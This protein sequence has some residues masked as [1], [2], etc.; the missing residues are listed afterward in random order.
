[1][2]E[3]IFRLQKG[4][5]LKLSIEKYVD[6]N[7]IKAGIIITCV[8]CLYKAVIRNAGGIDSIII[9]KDVEIVSITGTLSLDGCHIHMVVSDEELKTYGGHLKD[10]CL[11][12]TTAEIVILEFDDYIFK[13][14]ID[15]KTGYKELVVN[16]YPK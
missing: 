15:E 13:R 11:V 8:G 1:M 7:D 14:V 12:N 10:G 16:K 3:H 9:E 6:T 4:D 2:K 5:D